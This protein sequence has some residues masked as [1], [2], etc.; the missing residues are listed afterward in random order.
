[1]V[2]PNT[3]ITVRRASWLRDA[4]ALQTLRGRV[5]VEEQH[6][7]RDIE[8]DGRDAE[9]L[10]VIAERAGETVGCGRML[11]DGRIGRLAVNRELRGSGI[12][13]M[14]LQELLACAL[15]AGLR[16]VYLHA[17]VS[18]L[19]FYERA[20]FVADGDEFLEA[21]IVH[22]NMTLAIDYRDC[23]SYVRA[24][25]YP[26][27]FS[28]LAVSQARLARRELMLMS[29]NLDRSVFE[30]EAFASAL[31]TLVRETRRARI[32]ILVRDVR[33]IVERGHRLLALSRR[34]PSAIEMRRLAEHPNWNND[35][36]VLRDR[37]AVL[38]YPGSDGATGSYRPGEPGRAETELTR[39]EELW[40]ASVVDPELRSLSI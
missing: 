19:A 7:P 24:V 22:R 11:P 37:S 39:F 9:A 3:E 26:E 10:H 17:Q 6:V 29:P 20:G 31:S 5:F 35:T 8:W 30:R 18:A 16:E 32:R 27:L 1:M 21:D 28:E 34:L 38:S 12:G 13:A 23:D 25:S 4:D 2:T 14:L 40:R 33:S 36:V 15:E